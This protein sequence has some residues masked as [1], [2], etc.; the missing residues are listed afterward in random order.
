MDPGRCPCEVCRIDVGPWSAIACSS[1]GLVTFRAILAGGVGNLDD[2]HR[3]A[4]W[5]RI[6]KA[7]L[8]VA[9]HQLGRHGFDP[10]GWLDDPLRL[11]L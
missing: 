2:M 10:G 11:F 6:V 3:V 1:R 5:D 8:R 9:T 7:A 4:R